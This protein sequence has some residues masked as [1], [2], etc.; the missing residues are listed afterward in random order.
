ME[1]DEVDQFVDQHFR[2]N[3]SA[4]SDEVLSGDVLEDAWA[5]ERIGW[6]VERVYEEVIRQRNLRI[7]DAGDS[8][9]GLHSQPYI[10]PLKQNRGV[11]AIQELVIEPSETGSDRNSGIWLPYGNQSVYY[12]EAPNR[13]LTC[14]EWVLVTLV[15]L[16][17]M[18]YLMITS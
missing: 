3:S 11:D 1:Y 6:L 8:I 13:G 7:A 2:Q 10:P 9:S 18:L 17:L 4:A 5:D 15:V 14:V 12:E 16:G